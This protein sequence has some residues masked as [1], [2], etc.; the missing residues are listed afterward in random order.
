[1]NKLERVYLGLYYEAIDR[2]GEHTPKHTRV[3]LLLDRLWFNKRRSIRLIRKILSHPTE[4]CDYLF[5]KRRL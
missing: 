3:F 5:H 2:S 1:M 4:R